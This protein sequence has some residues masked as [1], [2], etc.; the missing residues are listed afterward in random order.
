M[1]LLAALLSNYGRW[2]CLIDIGTEGYA[3][4]AFQDFLRRTRGSVLNRLITHQGRRVAL[5]AVAI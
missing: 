1:I 2:F 3:V 4:P 5:N